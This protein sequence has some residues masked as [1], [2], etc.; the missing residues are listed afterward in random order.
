[1]NVLTLGKVLHTTV[2]SH[3]LSSTLKHCS[4]SSKTW[5]VGTVTRKKQILMKKRHCPIKWL[6]IPSMN[7]LCIYGVPC[8]DIFTFYK[9]EWLSG[10]LWLWIHHGPSTWAF[11]AWFIGAD[12][13]W[14]FDAPQVS[15]GT[16]LLGLLWPPIA[17]FQLDIIEYGRQNKSHP[18]LKHP[19]IKLWGRHFIH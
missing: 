7:P 19:A 5:S 10:W 9:S 1:M 13:N 4:M 3:V 14:E 16:L 18:G 6:W 12:L 8:S 15:G 17:S 11:L 2:C